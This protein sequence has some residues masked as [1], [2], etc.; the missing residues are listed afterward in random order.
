M[1]SNEYILQQLSTVKAKQPFLR[2]RQGLAR[3][4]AP[5]KHRNS[6]TTTNIKAIASTN[7]NLLS[8]NKTDKI[9]SNIQ[10]IQTQDEEDFIPLNQQVNCI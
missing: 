9:D 7:Y 5:P 2:K 4:E 1:K 8:K 10:S 3:Y 6:T